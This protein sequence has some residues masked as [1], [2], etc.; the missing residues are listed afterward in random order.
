MSDLSL[1]EAVEWFDVDPSEVGRDPY[2]EALVAAARA[3][4]EAPTIRFCDVHKS[5]WFGQTCEYAYIKKYTDPPNGCRM[6]EVL[7][8]PKGENP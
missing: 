5:R 3:V 1:Q 7:L 6:V 4:A 2:R 8:V